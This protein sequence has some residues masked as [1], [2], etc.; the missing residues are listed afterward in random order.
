[1]SVGFK[2]SVYDEALCI[3][4]LSDVSMVDDSL[5]D[6]IDVYQIG[7]SL[8][9]QKL[10][11]STPVALN[12]SKEKLSRL[13]LTELYLDLPCKDLKDEMF[14][15]WDTLKYVSIGGVVS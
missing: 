2:Y 6:T 1:M 5:L 9:I 12:F 4:I 14:S 10:C 8:R 11:S 15:G 7:K 13:K 3:R